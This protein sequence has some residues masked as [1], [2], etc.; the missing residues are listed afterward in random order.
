M[1]G[2]AIWQ[3]GVRP[4]LDRG[5]VAG[6]P[7]FLLQA[8]R[9]SRLS[10]RTISRLGRELYDR[11][12]RKLAFS[13]A[14]PRYLLREIP[15]RPVS[16]MPLRR[17]LWIK[18]LNTFCAEREICLTGAAVC[19]TAPVPDRD[20]YRAAEW[21]CVHA[22]YVDVHLDH[23]GEEL[24]CT[25]LRQFGVTGSGGHRPALE[26]AFGG[27]SRSGAPTLYLGERCERQSVSYELSP[28]WQ[29]KLPVPTAEEG[30][31]SLL[32]AGGGLRTEEI[33]VKSVGPMLDTAAETLYN[34]T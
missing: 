10:R 19:L 7:L 18:L 14:F 6:V 23:G 11:G 21:L 5:E 2:Y 34:A 30:L 24:R 28:A 1:Q 27:E 8:G 26:V 22:R 25:L 13:D 4:R 12:A 32:F 3:E 15:L 31:L 17:A 29:A 16:P 9:E 33:R 20:V